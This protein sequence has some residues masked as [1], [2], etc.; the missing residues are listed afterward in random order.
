MDKKIRTVRTRSTLHGE[1]RGPTIPLTKNTKTAVQVV[2]YWI[3]HKSGARRLRLR[4]EKVDIATGTRTEK[5]NLD[6]NATQMLIEELQILARVDGSPDKT[7]ISL[8]SFDAPRVLE[9]ISSQGLT[10]DILDGMLT[11]GLTTTELVVAAQRRAALKLFKSLLHDPV[12]FAE[13]RNEWRVAG[14]EKV[15]QMFFEM[16][17]WILGYGL[18]YQFGEALDD[19]SLEQMV[20]G[21]SV[22][23]RGKRVDALMKTLG[24]VNNLCFVEIK[25]HETD[26]LSKSS[27]R[28]GVY[29]PSSELS[30]A[31]AQVQVTVQATVERVRTKLEPID[32]EGYMD[33]GLLFA[34]CP[35]AMVIIGS[36]KSFW[37]EERP[38]IDMIRSFE[39]Y[40]RNIA[41]PVII[42]FDELYERA[43]SI[44][45]IEHAT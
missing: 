10:S 34:I 25:N 19:R 28:P 15:W 18:L 30:G 27:Y 8:P 33:S 21:Y 9:I 38:N 6:E 17:S 4:L 13:K 11:S 40:R 23:G 3:N 16:N 20:V 36:L 43:R 41:N 7:T 32:G 35:R 26:L 45:G 5:F 37:K 39:L 24:A 2:P 44:V 31:I 22:E 42:T 1:S 29:Q 14:S 12:A